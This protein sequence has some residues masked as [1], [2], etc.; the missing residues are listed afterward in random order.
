MGVT[1]KG[2]EK[3]QLSIW[4]YTCNGILLSKQKEQNINAHD[5]MDEP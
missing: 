3:H 5:N 2:C 1:I 4:L